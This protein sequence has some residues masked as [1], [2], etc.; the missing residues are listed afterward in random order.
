MLVALYVLGAGYLQPLNAQDGAE[1]AEPERRWEVPAELTPV[2]GPTECAALPRAAKAHL[3]PP[4]S[5][6]PAKAGSAEGEGVCYV[7]GPKAPS[8]CSSPLA[9]ELARDCPLICIAMLLE[10]VVPRTH[11]PHP[12]ELPGVGL[13]IPS[14]GDPA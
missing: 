5:T 8:R 12:R 14:W 11:A 7:I 9:A 10:S 1:R 2:K 4:P 13:G 3:T 6:V